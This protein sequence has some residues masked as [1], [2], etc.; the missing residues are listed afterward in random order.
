MNCCYTIIADASSESHV[1]ETD[2]H[3]VYD[4]LV[5]KSEEGHGSLCHAQN[6]L[7][8]GMLRALGY[9]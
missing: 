8:L 7:M 5:T 2:V 9:R 1:M 4:M 6:G 3:K